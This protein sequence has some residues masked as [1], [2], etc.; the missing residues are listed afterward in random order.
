MWT[1]VREEDWVL[2]KLL[3]SSMSTKGKSALLAPVPE[4]ASLYMPYRRSE[5]RNSL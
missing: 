3:G 5:V 2:T 1:G 4:M